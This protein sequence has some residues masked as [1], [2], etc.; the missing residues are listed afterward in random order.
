MHIYKSAYQKFV[1]FPKSAIKT[2]N[3]VTKRLNK[4]FI[5]LALMALSVN[6]KVKKLGSE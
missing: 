4:H 6:R 2:A 3:V 5:D 1:Y